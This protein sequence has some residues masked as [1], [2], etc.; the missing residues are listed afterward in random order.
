MKIVKPIIAGAVGTT[1][2]TLFSYGFSR[3]RKKEF[4]EPQLLAHLMAGPEGPY[5][6]DDLS[7][8]WLAHYL[9]GSVFSLTYQQFLQGRFIKNP[10]AK[11]AVIGGL[12]G[13]AGVVGWR[14]AFKGH[15]DPPK[16][17]YKEYYRHLVL[18]HIIFGSFAFGLL[19]QK[20]FKSF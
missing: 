5:R 7:K 15:P 14:A 17:D 16:I 8:G 19:E 1:F 2:M 13:L 11:G 9:V 3:L 4:R 6:G 12:Y 10:V 20:D 18:A